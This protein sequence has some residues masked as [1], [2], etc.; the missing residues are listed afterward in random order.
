MT[1]NMAKKKQT[2]TKF[3]IRYGV[4]G[5]FND[6]DNYK[7]IETTTLS[8]AETEAYNEACETYNTYEGSGGLRDIGEIM[9][10]DGVDEGEAEEIY[11][12]ERESWLDYEAFEYTEEKYNEIVEKQGKQAF[13]N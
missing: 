13:D 5:G 12:E 4:G 3:I 9:E 6:V 7:I 8:N 11:S 2:E 1:K 10:D